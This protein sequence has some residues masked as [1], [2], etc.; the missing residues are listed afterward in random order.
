[1]IDQQQERGKEN[2]DRSTARTWKRKQVPFKAQKPILKV[3]ANYFVKTRIKYRGR[4][5]KGKVQPLK[6]LGI[7]KRKFAIDTRREKKQLS[8]ARVRAELLRKVGL[9]KP[10]RSPTRLKSTKLIRLKV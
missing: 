3:P 1:L 2:V 6:N 8:V 7:E 9:K 4:K 10:R 5:V